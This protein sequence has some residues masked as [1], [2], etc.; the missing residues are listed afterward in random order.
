M[1]LPSDYSDRPRH[2]SRDRAQ[3]SQRRTQMLKGV[4]DLCVL[5]ALSDG[6]NYG[7]GLIET[8]QRLGIDPVAEGSIYPVLKRLEKGGLV[9]SYRQASSEGPLRKYYELTEPG[10]SSLS[11]GVTV[12][13]DLSGQVNN[14]LY[15]IH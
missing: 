15:Q 5:A 7:Y 14:A 12:W 3:Y 8:L 9:T 13:R 11:L 10:S 1:V 2:R 6:P 4:L